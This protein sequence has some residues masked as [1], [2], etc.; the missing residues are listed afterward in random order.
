[1]SKD[2]DMRFDLEKR[3]GKKSASSMDE[4]QERLSSGESIRGRPREG[5]KYEQMQRETLIEQAGQRG[6]SPR[7]DRDR[8]ATRPVSEKSNVS[9]KQRLEKWWGGCIH[10][11]GA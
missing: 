11:G 5:M 4:G 2:P 7:R 6:G 3:E 1:M 9:L 8:D 10:M